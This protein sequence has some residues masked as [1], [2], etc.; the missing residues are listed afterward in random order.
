MS[1]CAA[2]NPIGWPLGYRGFEKDGLNSSVMP[3]TKEIQLA[4]TKIGDSVV[5]F[6]DTPGFDDTDTKDSDILKVIWEYISTG[7]LRLSGLLYLHRI[8]DDRVGGTALKNL[9]MFQKLVG[10]HNMRNVILVTTMWGKLQPSDDGEARVK[11]LTETGKF[12]GGI[13]GRGADHEKYD[14]TREDALRI[15]HKMLDNA[16]C[17]LQ[18]QEEH[19]DGKKLADTA[20]G[21]EVT[22]RLDVLKAQHAQEMAELKEQMSRMSEV[23][24]EKLQ[25]ELQGLYKKELEQQRELAEAQ[26]KLQ[27]AEIAS[28]EGRL[29]EVESRGGCV[30]C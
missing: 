18:I 30:V 3:G 28:L 1:L 13:I 19:D 11:E 8:T 27:Q 16:P 26:T 5:R 9:S 7:D 29:A 6:I 25:Q 24:N 20:A 2:I 14:G 17:K 15:V 10:D 4:T 21:Q 12:W 23:G 22:D